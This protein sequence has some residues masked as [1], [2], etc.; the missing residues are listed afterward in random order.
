MK[1]ATKNSPT[2]LKNMTFGADAVPQLR[3]QK[4]LAETECAE[5]LQELEQVRGALLPVS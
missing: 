5:A 1:S 3:Q 4:H 2:D